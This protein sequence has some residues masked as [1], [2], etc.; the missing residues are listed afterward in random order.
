MSKKEQFGI[1]H[2]CGQYKKLTY[3]HIPPEASFNSVKQ[4]LCTVDTLLETPRSGNHPPWD[5][6]GLRYQQFQQGTGFYTLCGD[7]NSFTGAKYGAVYCSI[8]QAIGNEVLKTPIDQRQYGLNL[9]IENANLLAF[10]KQ[11]LSMFCSINEP[12]FGT[13]FRDFLLDENSTDF[14]GDRH[15]I[16]MYLHAGKVVRYVPFQVQGNIKTGTMTAFSE[17]STFPVGFIYYDVSGEHTPEFY[18]CDI[19]ACASC[20]YCDIQSVDVPVPFLT[21]D[22]PF[23]LDFR[24]LSNKAAGK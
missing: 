13:E 7:C 19:T 20:P 10:F 5:T 3:E 4:R 2:I 6:S 9:H 11:I 16:F 24:S 1:C 17:I 14:Y 8:I 18:G 22:T 12:P 23:G 15:K 21:C